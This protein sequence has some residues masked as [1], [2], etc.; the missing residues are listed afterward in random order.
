VKEAGYEACSKKRESIQEE[1]TP[2]RENSHTRSLSALTEAAGSL[3]QG[4][5]NHLLTLVII[6]MQ[7]FP[8]LCVCVTAAPL[9][10][11]EAAPGRRSE[12][13]QRRRAPCTPA[14]RSPRSPVTQ[15]ASHGFLA[16]TSGEPPAPRRGKTEVSGLQ[17]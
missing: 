8:L 12:V 15:P 17:S 4:R 11:R 9:H 16:G 3:G 6:L 1:R 7:I 14:E 2:C 5:T 13:T 10:A